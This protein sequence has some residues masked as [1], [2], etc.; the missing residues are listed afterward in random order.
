MGFSSEVNY[1]IKDL[2]QQLIN[3]FPIGNIAFDEVIARVTFDTPQVLQIPGVGELVQVG[4]FPIG[5]LTQY[6]TDKVAPDKS[7]PTGY[8]NL[9]LSSFTVPT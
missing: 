1:Y 3:E 5:V 9:H 7:S 6:V 8:Q 2:T 4:H